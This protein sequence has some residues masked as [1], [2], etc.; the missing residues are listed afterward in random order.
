MNVSGPIL[1][2]EVTIYD[3]ESPHHLQ[4]LDVLLQDGKIAK[5]GSTIR[6]DEAETIEAKGLGLSL[7]WLDLRSTFHD[8]G[9]EDRETLQTGAKAALAGGYTGVLLS[10]HSEPV[11][12][13][14]T[15]LEYWSK[16]QLGIDLL[17]AAAFSKGLEGGELSELFDLKQAGALA[18]SNGEKAISNSAFM[19]LALLYARETGLP[20]MVRSFDEGLS[21]G[22]QMHEGAQSTWLGLKGYPALAE[23]LQIERDLAL[24]EYTQASIHFM[25]ISS[26]RSVTLIAQAQQQGLKVTA[27]VNLL[28]LCYT[29][30][31]LSSYDTNLK[32]FP[33]LRAEADRQALIQG[34]K[35]GVIGGIASNHYPRTIEE[36]RCEFDLAKAGAA[37]LEIAFGLMGAQCP[38]LSTE[39]VVEALSRKGRAILAWQNELSIQEG[40]VVPL[41]LFDA[42]QSWTWDPKTKQSKA[43]NYPKPKGSLHGKALA[44][45]REGIWQNCTP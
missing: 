29:D 4:A 42:E 18:F 20:L 36:K 31:D 19:R 14:K 32:V 11:A 16:H 34:I 38:E 15:T 45:Y 41:T 8:P 28:N 27:D 40:R 33:P 12:D 30:E 35:E 39:E 3:R 5:I 17:P 10:P 21:A 23:E 24:C 37:S 1:L 13:Q 22:A 9:H 2:K 43:A 25:G 44:T 6:F 7:G 26:A